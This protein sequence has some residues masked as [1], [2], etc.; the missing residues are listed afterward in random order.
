MFYVITAGHG[1]GAP[2]NTWGGHTEA[3]LMTELRF[4]TA[5]KLREMGHVVKE[6][7]LR[8]ENWSLRDAMLLVGGA[9]MAVELHT[10]ASANTTATGVEVLAE[11]NRA[12]DA[13][14]IARAI[15]GVLQIP[16]RRDG[17]WYP[18][19]KYTQERGQSAGFVRVG[20]MIIEVFFQS[21][22]EDLRKYK[23][24]YW[25]VASAIARAMAEK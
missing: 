21:N 14:R 20:G 19:H 18:H 25:L 8:G 24:R 2:G 6:D 10:N 13:R 12:G 23:E 15:G 3:A 9:D 22:P 5:H 17:G 7:G 11:S 1:G 16:V 4:I